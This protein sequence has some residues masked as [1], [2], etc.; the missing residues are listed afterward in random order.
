MLKVAV[1]NTDTD[2]DLALD[3]RQQLHGSRNARIVAEIADADELTP[4]VQRLKPDVVI[5]YLH[6]E[7]D[8][9][10]VLASR[11][12][13]TCQ[14]TRIFAIADSDD[15]QLI[16]TSMRSGMCEFLTKPVDAEELQVALAK[17]EALKPPGTSKGKILATVGSTG[18][19]GT[20]FLAVNTACELVGTCK[21]SAVIVDMDFCQGQVATY[22]DLTPSF[23]LG[24]LAESS[25]ML[26]PQ[27][28]ERILTRHSSGVAVIGRPAALAQGELLHSSQ[29]AELLTSVIA[30]L[31]DMYDYVILDG[32]T[33]ANH[34]HLDLLRM[35]G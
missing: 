22:L 23:T 33:P 7:P 27:M 1:F 30:T 5:M 26:D 34:G 19:C 20:T 15:P 32:L 28:L 2:G 18:G 11:L 9:L 4:S 14:N 24:D 31:T 12:S 17:V 3:L 6:P 35:V 13:R 16:L 10:L 25:G 29:A 21:Q 8:P